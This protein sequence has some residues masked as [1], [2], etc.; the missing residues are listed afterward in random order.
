M[1]AN[2]NLPMQVD[3]LPNVTFTKKSNKAAQGD[4]T[5]KVDI[6]FIITGVI[7]TNGVKVRGR[8]D[9]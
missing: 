2:D 6:D 4:K 7:E 5:L 9:Q 3:V 8:E 1:F